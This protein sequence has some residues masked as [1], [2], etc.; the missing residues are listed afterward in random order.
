[1]KTYL[2][3]GAGPG[4][5]LATALHFGRQG[6][7]VVLA[8]RSAA[9]NATLQARFKEEGIEARFESVDSS[10]PTQ[11]ASLID[12]LS[13]ENLEVVHYNAAVMHYDA[14]GT[15]MPSR[16]DTQDSRDIASDISINVSGA[17][18]M[19]SKIIPAME[20]RKK[21]TILLTGGGFGVTP[22]ADFLTLSVGKAA[23]RSMVEALFEPLKARGVHIA[24]V[25][26]STLVASDPAHPERIAEAFWRLH[27]Q[28]ATEWTWEALYPALAA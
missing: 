19:L 4:I 8:S 16:I 13:H 12:R 26:V 15:L 22:S 14:S 11:V 25:R 18:A 17:L 24:T 6:Y 21:G 3:I 2:C 9:R 5:G 1:M 20:A 28:A 10:D 27:T 7:R 23:A